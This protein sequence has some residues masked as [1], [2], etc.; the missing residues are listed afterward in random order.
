MATRVLHLRHEGNLSTGLWSELLNVALSL[1]I[2]AIP[3]SVLTSFCC[4]LTAAVEGRKLPAQRQRA[5][6]RDRGWSDSDSSRLEW[7]LR[8][9]HPDSLLHGPFAQRLACLAGEQREPM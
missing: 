3:S 4:C 7:M 9:P 2:A 6:R 8:V 1:A 5:L